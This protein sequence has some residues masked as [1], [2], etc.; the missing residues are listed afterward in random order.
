VFAAEHLLGLA[1][2]DF[3]AEIVEALGEIARDVLARLRPFDEHREIV[4]SPLQRLAES[5]IA[6]ERL[7][8]LQDLLRRSLVLPE[9]GVRGLLLYLRELVGG[10][11]GVKDSSAD[12]TRAWRGPDTGGAGRRAA[13]LP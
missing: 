13:T 6:F 1:G 12:R 8:A 4:G 3:G 2:V 11:G 7:P 10:P 5:D 9:V